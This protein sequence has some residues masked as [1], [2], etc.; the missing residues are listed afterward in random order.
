ML[1]SDIPDAG[2]GL[3]GIHYFYFF[4]DA[5]Y[6]VEGCVGEQDGQGDTGEATAGADVDDLTVLFELEGGGDGQG[7]KDVFFVKAVD[8]LTGNDVDLIV[9]VLVKLFQGGELL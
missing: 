2:A 3:Y 1:G 4:T 8:I 5:V 6:Q 7:M 9:P